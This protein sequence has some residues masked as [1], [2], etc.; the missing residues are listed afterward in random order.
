MIRGGIWEDVGRK[1]RAGW[2]DGA[3]CQHAAREG[4]PQMSVQNARSQ[5]VLIDAFDGERLPL[6]SRFES[7]PPSSFMQSRV[8]TMALGAEHP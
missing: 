7:A 4:P 2:M 5:M 3:A 6:T 8:V 1:A